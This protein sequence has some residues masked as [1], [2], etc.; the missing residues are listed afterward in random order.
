[1]PKSGVIAGLRVLPADPLCF[2]SCD[3]FAFRIQ[4]E[5]NHM[6]AKTELELAFK[7]DCKVI[8]MAQEYPGYSE[9]IK[10]MILTDLSEQEVQRKYSILLQQF[11]PFLVL[12]TTI[13]E[14]IDEYNRNEDKFKKRMI[15]N[16]GLFA[17]DEEAERFHSE[18]SVPSADDI[19]S[20]NREKNDIQERVNR[21]LSKLSTVQRRRL[22]KHYIHGMTWKEIGDE[23]GRSDRAIGFSIQAAKKKFQKF[24]R[25][26]F[27]NGTPLSKH[28]EGV[29]SMSGAISSS[30]KAKKGE[31]F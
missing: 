20:T 4:A 15:R 18:L 2:L 21:T 12:P 17:I 5:R 8:Y 25:K 23:E 7:E 26:D 11:H 31:M 29:I 10:C 27:L 28:S 14:T 3:F 19:I 30:D 1:M 22:I 24:W 6:K 9:E 13:K 16:T